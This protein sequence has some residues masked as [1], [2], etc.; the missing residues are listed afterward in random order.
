MVL[1]KVSPMGLLL[2]IYPIEVSSTTILF[3]FKEIKC[4]KYRCVSSAFQ[5]GGSN[6]TDD[7]ER[8]GK[9]FGDIKYYSGI[10]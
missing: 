5:Y 4:P 9:L 2:P 6:R 1:D 3:T 7:R 8:G 10:L